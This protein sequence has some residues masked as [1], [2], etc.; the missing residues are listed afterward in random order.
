[1]QK[2][3]KLE[4]VGSKRIWHNVR[5]KHV[6]QKSK[7]TIKWTKH[8]QING[9][10]KLKIVNLG[11]DSINLRNVGKSDKIKLTDLG[12]FNDWFAKQRRIK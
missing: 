8:K 4:Y 5:I 10:R 12:T 7:F 6:S 3:I 1:M 2:Q 11:L 9:N